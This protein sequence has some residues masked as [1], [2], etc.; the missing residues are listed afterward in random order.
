MSSNFDIHTIL[1]K[2]RIQQGFFHE[3][4]RIL[5]VCCGAVVMGLNLNTFVPSAGMLPGGFTGFVRL[6]QMLFEKYADHS[7]PFSP[8]YYTLNLIAVIICFRYIGKKFTLYS[9]LMIFLSGL[10]A[11]IIPNCSLNMVFSSL[12]CLQ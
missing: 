10:L 1:E 5:L 3:L 7:I 4:R 12:V 11:D 2:R 6:V 9:L 8:I